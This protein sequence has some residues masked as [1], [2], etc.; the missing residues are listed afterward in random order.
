MATIFPEVQE[1]IDRLQQRITQTE[2]EIADL[3]QK[4]KEAKA[5]VR[6]WKKAISAMTGQ[7]ATNRKKR[8]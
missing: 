2:R 3:T 6:A 8:G 5:N 1:A 7:S 4:R